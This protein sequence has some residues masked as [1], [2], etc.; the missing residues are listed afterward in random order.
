MSEKVTIGIPTYNRKEYLRLALD[1]VVAQDYDNLEIIVSDN[2]STDGTKDMMREYMI[3]HPKSNIKYYRMEKNLGPMPNWDN[4]HKKATGEY[5]MI[6]SDDDILESGAITNMMAAFEPDVVQVIGN[7]IFIDEKGGEMHCKKNT[8]GKYDSQTFWDYRLNKELHDTPS[9]VMIRRKIGDKVFAVATLADS[10]MDVATSLLLCEQGQ[11][12]C[13]DSY[14][15]RYRIHGGNDTNNLYRCAFSHVGFYQLFKK[16]GV[17]SDK[18][19]WLQKYCQDV[20]VG[21]ANRARVQHK[22]HLMMRIL[23]LL[24]KRLDLNMT[25]A[26]QQTVV[27]FVRAKLR[28]LVG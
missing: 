17:T 6:L 25:D 8:P 20:I 19:T 1:S 21:Y 12:K 27:G 24:D 3:M 14:V 2:H 9:A 10:A 4:C 7:V 26:W 13:I 16:R 18:L 15:V 23:F 22:Y 28:K 5:L 11:I